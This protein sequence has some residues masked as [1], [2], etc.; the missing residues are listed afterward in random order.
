MKL[1]SGLTLPG[2]SEPFSQTPHELK[3]QPESL[4]KPVPVGALLGRLASIVE[5]S[6]R[7]YHPQPLEIS[8]QGALRLTSCAGTP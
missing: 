6:P 2:P 7:H 1:K 4:E 8:A 5:P 3:L